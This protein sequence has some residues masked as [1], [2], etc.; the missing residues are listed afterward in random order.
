MTPSTTTYQPGELILVTFPHTSGAAGRV[1]PA[2]VILDTGDADV[3]L[4]RITS[5]PPR[6]AND[7]TVADWQGAGL[8][9]AS[10]IR[11]HKL[12]TSEKVSV[13]GR[14]GTLQPTDRA[15]VSAVLRQLYGNW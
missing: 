6:S 5:K 11:L 9:G 12:T 8:R 14:V 3:L 4:A 1:R 7:V 13:L 10:T 15:A 2:L